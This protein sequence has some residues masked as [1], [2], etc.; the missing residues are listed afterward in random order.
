ME[1]T[2]RKSG[3]FKALTRRS[4]S[5][6]KQNSEDVNI[7]TSVFTLSSESLDSTFNR[8]SAVSE[9]RQTKTKTVLNWLRQ[10]RQRRRESTSLTEDSLMIAQRRPLV[11]NCIYRPRMSELNI[12]L[13]QVYILTRVPT[14]PPQHDWDELRLHA[15][16]FPSPWQLPETSQEQ[17]ILVNAKVLMSKYGWYRGNITRLNAQRKLQGQPDGSF[18]L[19]DSQTSGTHFTLSFRSAGIT[20]HYRIKYEV[21]YWFIESSRYI[22]VAE[23]IKDA[24]EK[25]KD[26]VFC[27]VK[28]GKHNILQPPFPVRLTNPISKFDEV[29]KLQHI[30]RFYIRTT[31]VPFHTLPTRLQEYVKENKYLNIPHGYFEG[32]S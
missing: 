2:G 28:P 26:S 17:L 8:Q 4:K 6:N 23:M 10:F 30:C 16:L 25:S 1:P 20:L 3:W 5:S 9:R 27:Y 31:P 7:D 13:D 19:R 21:G 32:V 15:D 22:S 24:M 29:P 18:L 11:R 12:P 14:P